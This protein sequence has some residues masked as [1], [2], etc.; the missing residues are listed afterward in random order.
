MTHGRHSRDV[1]PQTS[2]Q[3]HH[4]HGS[5]VAYLVMQHCSDVPGGAGGLGVTQVGELACMTMLPDV[6]LHAHRLKALAC[7][8]AECLYLEWQAEQGGWGPGCSCP[9][10]L[11]AGPSC[12]T[13]CA[14]RVSWANV[15]SS[16]LGRPSLPT[17]ASNLLVRAWLTGFASL[18]CRDPCG[19]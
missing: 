3:H 11:L 1:R 15:C 19:W 5:G 18:S 2:A 16:R 8:Q 6:S 17:V 14:C 13:T 12:L 4:G 7:K 9:V 10:A